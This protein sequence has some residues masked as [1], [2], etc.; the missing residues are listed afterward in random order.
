MADLF[1]VLGRGMLGSR[2]LRG[3]ER[4]GCTRAAAE[5][6]GLVSDGATQ[7]AQN[8]HNRILIIELVNQRKELHQEHP[9]LPCNPSTSAHST[10][11]RA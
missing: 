8:M 11:P 4:K 9:L 3:S 7:I 1:R 5:G 6:L 10:V 2:L